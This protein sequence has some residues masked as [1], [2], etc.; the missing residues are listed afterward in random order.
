MYRIPLLKS[1]HLHTILHRV[2]FHLRQR[3]QLTWQIHSLNCKCT[4]SCHATA[5]KEQFTGD[6]FPPK[7]RLV[8][9][10]SNWAQGVKSGL[11]K[12]CKLEQGQLNMQMFRMPL[13]RILSG[14]FCDS[15]VRSSAQKIESFLGIA[16][17]V[18]AIK[19]YFESPDRIGFCGV[20][21]GNM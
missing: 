20:R 6:G 8:V 4:T 16:R 21:W 15:P 3:K 5:T 9:D 10:F 17:V 19:M 12:V 7:I 18:R 1:F 11:A 14:V 2:I 13:I